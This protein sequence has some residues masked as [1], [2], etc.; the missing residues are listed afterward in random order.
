MIKI[1]LIAEGRRPVV[2]SGPRL[3]SSSLDYGLIG[4]VGLLIVGVLAAGGHWYLLH[5]DLVERKE[6]IAVAKREVDEL[7]PIIAEVE[8]YKRSKAELQRKITIIDSLKSEQKIP[9]RV[10]DEV[11]KALPGLLW[12]TRLEDRKNKLTVA[13]QALNTNAVATFIENLDNVEFFDEPILKET[14]Q[15]NSVYNFVISMN[16][17]RPPPASG[18]GEGGA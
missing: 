14:R 4:L 7:A 11:S 9:V 8:A 13:G 12:L 2:A 6:Q 10:M 16:F 1:N 3:T 17:T 15:R 18:T 5:R